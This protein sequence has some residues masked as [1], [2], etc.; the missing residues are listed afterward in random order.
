MVSVVITG[1][2]DGVLLPAV[3]V[4]VQVSIH[5]M[6]AADGLMVRRCRL[7]PILDLRIEVLQ[8]KR[9]EQPQERKGGINSLL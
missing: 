8:L 4:L 2:L 9:R 3:N 1:V 5:T 7:K 6:Y